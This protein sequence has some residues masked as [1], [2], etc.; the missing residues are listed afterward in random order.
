MELKLLN[1]KMTDVKFDET[2]LK[3]SGYASVF[4]G[5]DSYN[6]T[7]VKG[8]YKETLIGRERE[9]KLRWNHHGGV[10]GKW[11]EIKEDDH[12]LW[13]EG[14]LTPN[15]SLAN[16][17]AASMKHGAIDG[18]SIGYYVTDSEQKG[19]I[20]ELKQIELIEISVVEEPADNF[21]RVSELKSLTECKS[22]KD[23][24]K[25]IRKSFGLSQT[26][27]TAIVSAVKN[28]VHGERE[29]E[30]KEVENFI[31]NLNLKVN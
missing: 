28:V 24:E 11:T 16:D 31:K 19:N 18:M 21:A 22:L 7:I 17:V 15:H 14:E 1:T 3:F 12:G 9:V 29:D 23:I 30:T 6:D 2:G 27:A 10:I 25:S 5:V 26:E 4:N 13:V 20:R 8:A